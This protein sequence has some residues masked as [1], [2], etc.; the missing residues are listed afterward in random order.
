MMSDRE[1]EMVIWAMI[2]IGAASAHAWGLFFILVLIRLAML[3][4]KNTRE[5]S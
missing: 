5:P 2:A 3:A 1:A 4:W